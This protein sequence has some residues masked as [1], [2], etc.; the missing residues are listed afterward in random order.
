MENKTNSFNPEDMYHMFDLKILEKNIWYFKNVVSYPEDLLKFINEVDEDTRSHE[1]ITKWSPWTAS[2]DTTFVYG[3]N[4]YVISNNINNK[5]DNA[6][7]DQKILYIKNSFEMAFDMC[8]N[9]YL[10][11]HGLDKNH[12]SL[13]MQQIPIRRWIKGPGMG[14]HCDGYDGDTSLAFSMITYLNEDYEGGEIE[15]PN[16]NMSLKPASGSLLIFPSQEP[17][18][19][20]VNPI[21]SGERY[22][23]HLSVYKK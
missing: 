7:L 2:D 5:I 20:K 19:H 8:L 9:Q 23:S 11:Q 6:R 13:P 12:Y 18:L 22:T 1:I 14:P 21:L 3:D 16:H 17:Y 10:A 15:F 4:K